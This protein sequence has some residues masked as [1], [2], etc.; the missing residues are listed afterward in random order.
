[1]CKPGVY[2]LSKLFGMT[3]TP[4]RPPVRLLYSDAFKRQLRDLAKR[5]R[6]IRADLQ[7]VLDQLQAG[8]TPGDQ[9]RG[10]GHVLYKV[11]VPNRDARRGKSG[12][13]RVIYYLQT[14]DDRL[15]VTLY[16]KSDQAD[17][18]AAELRKIIE[19]QDG[20]AEAG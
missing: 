14:D 6:H 1:M 9:V 4:G 15:L 8:D 11:R 18:T 13:Y 3:L 17:V 2:S 10:I 20:E 7:P 16:S 5:Y 19:S 12:G